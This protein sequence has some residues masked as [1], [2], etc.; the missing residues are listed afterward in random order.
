MLGHWW[1]GGNLGQ[2][3]AIQPCPL[4]KT[5]DDSLSLHSWE[6]FCVGSF[7]PAGFWLGQRRLRPTGCPAA[8]L[9]ASGSTHCSCT[10]EI[11]LDTHKC[12]Q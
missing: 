3:D 9:K 11:Q 12:Q 2:R 4:S 10:Q 8:P 1:G 7:K 5:L 6:H